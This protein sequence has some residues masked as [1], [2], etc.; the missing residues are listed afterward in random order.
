MSNATHIAPLRVVIVGGGIAAIET[1]LAVHDLAEARLRVTLVAPQP[2]LLLAP[3]AVAVPFNRGH[4]EHVPLAAFMSARGGRFVL[5]TAD[6]VDPGHR[7]VTLSCGEIVDYDVLVLA[8]GAAR[9]AAFEHGL[10][11]GPDPR[12]LTSV[13]MRLEQN[14][15]RS[16]AFVVPAGCTWSLPLY[17]LALM[18]AR[19]V[20]AMNANPVDVHI[21]TPESQPLEIFGPEAGAAVAQLLDAAR[22]VLHTGVRA[23]IG[24]AGQIETGDGPPIVVDEIVALPIHEGRPLDGVPC[25]VDGFIAVGDCG[26]VDGL[27]DVY[28]I[29]DATDRPIKH[30][31]L[32]CQQADVA[33]AHIAARAGASID[34]PPLRQVLSGRLLTGTSDLFLRRAAGA[35]D[36][37]ASRE[38]LSW[39][40]AKVDGRYLAPYLVSS[41]LVKLPP[42]TAHPPPGIDVDVQ[43][44]WQQ[45]RGPAV[46]GL[47]PLGPTTRAGAR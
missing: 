32:A 27:D 14:R 22:I 25:N 35:P 19:D 13:L 7:T 23:E 18:T 9:V 37:R 11:F 5:A 3:L 29:G 33:A 12:A 24:L 36:G 34:I 47:S 26:L 43:L 44:T 31:G 46:L 2:D 41:G 8:H 15:S 28:A 38:Q 30:G 42:R 39:S 21:V 6:R 17:E 1:A 45:R 20:W 16:V 4:V 40:P 10:T